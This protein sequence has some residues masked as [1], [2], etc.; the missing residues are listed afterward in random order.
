MPSFHPPQV[1]LLGPGPS[2]VPQRVLDALARPTIGHLDPRFVGM[3]DEVKDL[4]RFAFQ[5][6]NTLTVPVSAPRPK[7][8]TK[9]KATQIKRAFERSCGRRSPLTL[10]SALATTIRV[11][12]AGSSISFSSSK[13]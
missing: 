11:K 4:L 1:L 7:S 9:N 12:S 13:A 10:L 5:T 2:P 6:S 3:M 8:P